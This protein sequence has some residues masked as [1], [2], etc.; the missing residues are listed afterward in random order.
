MEQ[1]RNGISW[2]EVSGPSHGGHEQLEGSTHGLREPQSQLPPGRAGPWPQPG[3]VRLSPLRLL[4]R[5]SV[6]E[7]APVWSR[8]WGKRT[9]DTSR[10][11]SAVL[12][13]RKR[14]VFCSR[15]NW[16]L[17]QKL[18]SEARQA[19]TTSPRSPFYHPEAANGAGKGMVLPRFGTES[20]RAAGTEPP[21]SLTA[22]S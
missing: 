13:K 16:F 8:L 10:N 1:D 2:S 6:T 4:P 5:R 18:K 11:G 14:P 20:G 19:T 17:Q 12:Q 21:T 3:S 15:E 22:A 9:G 7:V